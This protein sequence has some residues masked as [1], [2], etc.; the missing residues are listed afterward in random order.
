MER[1][2][3]EFC[4]LR[5]FSAGPKIL[6]NTYLI[7]VKHFIEAIT[8]LELIIIQIV[9]CDEDGMHTTKK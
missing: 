7:D 1:G 5:K 6:K 4:R 2:S 8:N 3:A 9:V